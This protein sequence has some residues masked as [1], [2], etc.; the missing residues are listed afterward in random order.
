M[1]LDQHD[2]PLVCADGSLE[3]VELKGPESSVV[4]RYRN[5]LIVS[6]EVHEAVSQ[7]ISYL[8]TIDEMG[9]GLR[10]THRNEI[11]QDYDYRRA[12]GVVVIG[13]P[14][15]IKLDGVSRENVD[16]AVRSYNAHLSRVRVVTYADLLESAE[17]AL[18]FEGEVS[19]DS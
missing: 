17:R 16:Q 15:R 13:H 5:H 19:G 2:I 4:K 18:G 11:G 9:A 14:D 1:P 6:C 12:R 10:T 3:I 8:R 7:C